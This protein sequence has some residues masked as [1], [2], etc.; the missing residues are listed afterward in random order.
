MTTD[1]GNHKGPTVIPEK[2][3]TGT[4]EEI[5]EESQEATQE[6]IRE[7]IQE[8]IREGT[9]EAI[10]GVTHHHQEIKKWQMPFDGS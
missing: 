2:G 1:M 8:G 5:Q 7:A 6:V 3:V 9:L 10:Q 4:Q